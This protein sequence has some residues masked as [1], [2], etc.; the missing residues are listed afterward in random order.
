MQGKPEVSQAIAHARDLGWDAIAH[1][2]RA[3]ARGSGDSK[4]DIQRD[5]LIIDTDLKL[6]AKWDPKRYGDKI[7]NEITGKD[8]GPIETRHAGLS[9]EELDRL[10]AEKVQA[11]GIVLPQ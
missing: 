3:T 7:Q 11:A 8:G 10:I 4:G 5:K 9:D 1:K 2:A 6:L